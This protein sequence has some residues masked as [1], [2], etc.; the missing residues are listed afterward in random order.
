MWNEPY[1]PRLHFTRAVHSR[2]P[3]PGDRQCGLLSTCRR[4]ESRTYTTCTKNLVK[5]ALVVPEIS[6]RTDRHTHT[7]IL[8]TILRRHST[9]RSNKWVLRCFQ[10]QSRIWDEQMEE[11]REFQI[12]C[13]C[14]TNMFVAWFVD[15]DFS[16]FINNTR[17]WASA[18]RD[19]HPAEYRWRPLF[20][21]AKFS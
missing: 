8:I 5:I 12:D 20:N 14:D 11:A 3:L 7:D 17:M 16:N 15:M 9:W 19:G 4:T 10:N 6:C 2:H 21:A 1:L 13:C 18:Q